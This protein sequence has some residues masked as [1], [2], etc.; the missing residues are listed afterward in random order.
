MRRPKP[1]SIQLRI[2]SLALGGDGVAH[3]ETEHGRRAI[4]VPS[5]FPGDLITAEVDFSRK[6][7]RARLLSIVE[8]SPDR[9]EP[10]CRDEGVCGGCDWMRLRPAAQLEAHVDIVRETLSR[11]LGDLP[12]IEAHRAPRTEGYRTRARLGVR[13]NGSRA[14]VGY[15]GKRS[16]RLQDVEN[17]IVLDE[18]LQGM[19]PLLRSLLRSEIGE[20]DASI[21]LGDSGRPVV[22]LKWRGALRGEVFATIEQLV[23]QGTLAGAALWLDHAAMPARIGDP[24]VVTLGGDGEPLGIPSGGFAQAFPEVSVHLAEE[25][26]RFLEPAGEDLVELFA[27]SGNF[28]VTLARLAGSV[29]A[30]ESQPEAAECARSNLRARGLEAKVVTADADSFPIP[31]KARKLLLDPPRQGAPGACQRIAA[32]RV[33]RVVYVSCDPG[34]LARDLDGLKEAGFRVSRIAT[35]EMFPHTSHMETLVSLERER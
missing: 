26:A 24:S 2:E 9:V 3:A 31:R 15:L 7:A 18:R 19:L 27:G 13:A 28:T 17:C 21:A 14:Q 11:R 6:P 20:G 10:S 5:A 35:F 30:V 12:R 32:S 1:A 33:R 22:E 23:S 34:T 25:A 4:F 29:V 8:P 16:H